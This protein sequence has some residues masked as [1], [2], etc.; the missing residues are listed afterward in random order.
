MSFSEDPQCQDATGLVY[1]EQHTPENGTTTASA[2]LD[3]D[4]LRYAAVIK[5]NTDAVSS[6]P[7][8]LSICLA[9]HLSCRL[10]YLPLTA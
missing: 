9:N 4:R 3:A 1:V 5:P 8:C 10:V 7:F 2:G 6:Q